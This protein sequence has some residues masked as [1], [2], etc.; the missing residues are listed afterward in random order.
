VHRVCASYKGYNEQNS[1]LFAIGFEK[2][3]EKKFENEY[4][5]VEN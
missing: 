3:F 2:K 5:Q 4:K 1:N